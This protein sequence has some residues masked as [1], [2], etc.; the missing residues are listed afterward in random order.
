MLA[1]FDA[2]GVWQCPLRRAWT[3]KMTARPCIG[4]LLQLS[5][6]QLLQFDDHDYWLARAISK[7]MIA[8]LA[9]EILIT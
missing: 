3:Q 7:V 8:S 5:P 9:S 2:G 6:M 1:A 4:W